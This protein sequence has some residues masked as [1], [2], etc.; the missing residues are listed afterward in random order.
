MCS[1]S[2]YPPYEKNGIRKN[3]HCQQTD[4]SPL[5]LT[6]NNIVRISFSYSR[7]AQKIVTQLETAPLLTKNSRGHKYQKLPQDEDEENED[8][9]KER[10]R[11]WWTADRSWTE[12]NKSEERIDNKKNELAEKQMEL[13][14]KQKLIGHEQRSTKNVKKHDQK[15]L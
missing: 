11:K 9:S 15:C 2:L 7:C 10:D 1:P 14:E 4:L 8:G 12:K 3:N 13:K 6:I 5:W